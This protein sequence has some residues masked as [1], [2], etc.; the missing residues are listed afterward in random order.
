MNIAALEWLTFGLSRAVSA[1][2]ERG[3]VLHLLTADPTEYAF[4]V[5]RS[6][7][8]N[9]VVHDV[10]TSDAD[11]VLKVLSSI[12]DLAGLISTTDVCSLT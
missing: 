6:I 3:C 9:L 4:E 8:G 12:D 11:Q 5:E 2:A 10:D 1:A 7:P